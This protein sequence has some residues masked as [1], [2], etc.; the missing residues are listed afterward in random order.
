MR[1]K[2]SLVDAVVPIAVLITLLSFSVFLFGDS[3]SAG[4]NQIAMI[5]AAAVAALIA[6]K[7][8]NDW[9][10]IQNAI[11]K[12]ISTAM[13]AVLILLAVGALIGSWNLAG[14]VQAMIYFGLK[15]LSPD[16]FYVAT[17]IICA[18]TSLAIGS[19]W[20]V[21]GTLGIGLMGVSQ[22]LGLSPAM[23]AGAVISGAY[24]GD[25]MSPLSDTTNLAPAVA[26]VELF[27]HI[28][29]MLWT[30]GPSFVIAI[31]IFSFIGLG[32]VSTG[33]DTNMG[34]IGDVIAANYSLSFPTL[35]PLALVFY[36][37]LKRYPALPTILAGA[38]AGVLVGL[39]IQ[40]PAVLAL[41]D[42][43]DL[44]VGLALL[45]GVWI[46]LFDGFVANTG[47]EMVDN[48]LSRGGMNS[49]LSTI[50]LV[51][52][53]LSFGAVMEYSGMLARL[54][55]SILAAA[56]STGSM[57][58]AVLVTSVGVNIV[59]ADQY[60]AIVLPGRMYRAEFSRRGL[61]PKNLSRAI[62]DAG[63]ITSPLIPWNTCGAYMAAT[64]GVPTLAY[65]P[66]CFFNLVNPLISMLYG[67]RGITIEKLE[68]TE[69]TDSQA[70]SAS[71]I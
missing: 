40:R 30:T 66:Y 18:L 2:P 3:S 27:S 57:I 26:G 53:A 47:Y 16:I 4:P 12:G 58:A 21:A 56:K 14:T 29:H 69:P 50:F 28:R 71:S 20:T 59:A 37:A 60:L 54:I 31:V 23:T 17:C 51:F 48:L 39:I 43:P 11:V 64:L 6:L 9:H 32:G 55:E 25:K 62:E 52:S 8:G 68:K 35:I 63:T 61:H 34:M 38:L 42:S 1:K 24:F 33:A 15:I 5:F 22:G 44:P 70:E 46:T 7:N 10:S 49:M 41:A 65:L 13:A 36:L 67:F 19:S 45:K